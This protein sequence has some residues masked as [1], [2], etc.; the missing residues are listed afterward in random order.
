MNRLVIRNERTETEMDK[1]F[2]TI[3]FHPFA[4]AGVILSAF[5]F[6]NDQ[7]SAISISFEDT[8][9]LRDWLNGEYPA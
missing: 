7:V 1:A 3:T 6:N 8:I 9:R 2:G 5:N 4:Q